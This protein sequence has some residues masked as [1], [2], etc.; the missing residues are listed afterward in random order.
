MGG[1]EVGE[2]VGGAAATDN[3]RGGCEDVEGRG[4]DGGVRAAGTR[5]VDEGDAA[6]GA[7]G[8]RRVTGGT[9]F[10]TAAA[11]ANTGKAVKGTCCWSLRV[12]GSSIDLQHARASSANGLPSQPSSPL[13]TH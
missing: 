4:G 8:R 11:A 2:T 6:G 3:D 13:P 10:G 5:A 9:G 7:R 12:R 1:D